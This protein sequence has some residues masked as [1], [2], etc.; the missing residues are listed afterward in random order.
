M[1]VA[2]LGGAGYIGSHCA[3]YLHQQGY[4]VAVYDQVLHP[5]LNE[6]PAVQGDISDL[7]RLRRFFEDYQV[8]SVIHC[9]GKIEVSE[10]VSHPDLYYLYNV[11]YTAGLLQLMQT[12]DI[13]EIIFSSSCAVYGNPQFLP[14]TESHPIAPLS[15]YGATKVAAEELLS[16]A[17]A[18]GLRHVSLRFFNAA[19]SD[20]EGQLGE[21]HEPETH[22]IPRVLSHLAEGTPFGIFG[23]DYPTPDGTCIRDYVH[24]WDL[25]QAHACALRYLRAQGTSDVF[26]LGND[27]GYSVR[28]VVSMAETVVNKSASFMKQARRPGDPAVLV[29]SSEKARRVL[30]WQPTRQDLKVLV[31]DA[32]RYYAY[33]RCV[34]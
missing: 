31:E 7:P 1:T 23:D 12:L 4:A 20:P 16:A 28:E 25:A 33:A 34:G 15:P 13:Q 9:A 18:N 32:W 22:L 24:V 29:S 5:D 17:S 11:D 14:L 8:R 3:R 27:R 19:G 21:R 10:S 26:N 6:V 2:I 30:G